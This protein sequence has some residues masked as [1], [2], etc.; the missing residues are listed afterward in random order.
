[1]NEH[2]LRQALAGH[3]ATVAPIA[4]TGRLE[5]GLV[6][7]DRMRTIRTACASTAIGAV[8]VF[9]AMSLGGE[10]ESTS[11][12]VV[13][14]PTTIEPA[15]DGDLPRIGDAADA[16]DEPDDDGTMVVAD[17]TTTT[18]TTA[19][20]LTDEQP[21]H[22]AVTETTTTTVPPVTTA[23][24]PTTTTAPP[25]TTTTTTIGTAVEFTAAAR[26]GSCAE[27]PPY[28]DYSG[29]AAPGTTITVTSPY[30][31]PAQATADADGN[32]SLRVEFPSAP[33]N[34]HFTV[35]VSDGAETASFDFVHTV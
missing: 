11:I 28:D 9:G 24:A 30:S 29:T 5:A 14:T 7:A 4:D 31:A 18:S 34:E 16:E 21:D 17:T 8:A 6:R 10:A 15:P 27:D 19:P 35:D 25:P 32:W 13:D 33:A 20:P 1:M 22:L 23:P 12:D 2:E 3:A 26:Y